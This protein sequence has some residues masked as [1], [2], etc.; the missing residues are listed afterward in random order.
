M[1]FHRHDWKL[2]SRDAVG[3]FAKNNTPKEKAV[4][5]PGTVFKCQECPVA[6][7]EP[8]NLKLEPV[9]VDLEQIPIPAHGS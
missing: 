4:I 8:D 7:L 1:I 3:W 9:E 5:V 6:I 2:V